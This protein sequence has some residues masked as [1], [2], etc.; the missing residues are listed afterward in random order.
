MTRLHYVAGDQRVDHVAVNTNDQ[1]RHRI[2]LESTEQSSDRN[3]IN[4][5]GTEGNN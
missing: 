5:R 3:L 2:T 4:G 1:S